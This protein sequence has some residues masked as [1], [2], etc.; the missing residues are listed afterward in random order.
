[1][2]KYLLSSGYTRPL[3]SRG[4]ATFQRNGACFTIR[5]RAVPIQKRSAKQSAVKNRFDVMQ[6]NW[7]TLSGTD[8]TEWQN[9]TINYPRTDSLG[10]IYIISRAN[11]QASSN[12]NLVNSQ[13]PTLSYPDPFVPVGN[14]NFGGE[15]TFFNSGIVSVW[16]DPMIIPAG[17][18]LQ[19]WFSRPSP[20]PSLDLSFQ[21]LKL[22]KTWLPGEDSSGNIYNEYILAYGDAL[23]PGQNLWRIAFQYVVEN[24]GQKSQAFY[25]NIVIVP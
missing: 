2:A 13:L 8:Q 20:G 24:T 10:N 4:G 14:P 19:V 18:S 16:N 12:I 22:I 25:F 1:M 23:P 11:L 15:A 3:G 5:K 21:D 6:K 9:E 17:V 7:K